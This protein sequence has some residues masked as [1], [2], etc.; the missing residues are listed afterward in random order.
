MGKLV[1]SYVSDD[2]KRFKTREAMEAYELR[3][4]YSSVAEP[5]MAHSMLAASF[6]GMQPRA[7]SAARTRLMDAYMDFLKVLDNTGMVIVS[8]SDAAV[9]QKLKEEGVYN[10][11]LG[12]ATQLTERPVPAEAV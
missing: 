12:S 3:Q 5:Y 11:V 6:E 8:A 10:D 7:R 9:V 1:E 2:G 4:A